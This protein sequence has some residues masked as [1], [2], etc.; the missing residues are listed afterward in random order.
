MA[1]LCVLGSAACVRLGFDP[2]RGSAEDAA[3]SDAAVSDAV[4]DAEGPDSDGPDSDGPDGDGPD[5]SKTDVAVPDAGKADAPA[6]PTCTLYVN[7]AATTGDTYTLAPGSNTNA[8][9][10]AAPYATLQ[11]ALAQAASGAVICVD[12]GSYAGDISIVKSVQLIGVR[13]GVSACGRTGV[14][15]VIRG[16]VATTDSATEVTLD[17]LRL[18]RHPNASA[19]KGANLIWRSARL[20]LVNTK[21][22]P[23]KPVGGYT[24]FGYIGVRVNTPTLTSIEIRGNEFSSLVNA[25]MCSAIA[26]GQVTVSGATTISSNCFNNSGSGSTI[27]VYGTFDALT[28]DANAVVNTTTGG[29]GGIG[30]GSGSVKTLT[31]TN[32]RVINAV[33]DGINIEVNTVS[34]GVISGNVI[35][36]SGTSGPGFP[37]LKLDKATSLAA[38]ISVKYNDLSAAAGTNKALVSEMAAQAAASCNWYGS[39]KSA[40]VAA[41]VSGKV[42]F[43]PF[44][45]SGTDTDTSAPGFQP[46]SGT[47]NGS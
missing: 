9:T 32:N 6:P 7:D 12:A 44:L 37:N 10:A 11:Y 27:V 14:E 31:V 41:L 2:P 30:I 8:G 39:S 28:L 24:H 40:D 15:S 26:L 38:G 34:G 43:T 20:R 16:A 17:G 5:A 47:C 18:E 1:L 45:T 3:V 22:I 35:H 36:G 19:W 25:S 33:K 46:G 13:Q 29:A 23:H 42:S 21:V 4:S